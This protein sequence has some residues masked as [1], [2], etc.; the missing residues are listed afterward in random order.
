M[1]IGFSNT[2]ASNPMIYQ[3]YLLGILL[4]FILTR[5]FQKRLLDE[6]IVL[7]L[8]HYSDHSLIR[9]KRLAETVSNIATIHVISEPEYN[10]MDT[11]EKL[12]NPVG[13]KFIAT[14]NEWQDTVINKCRQ[15]VAIVIDVEKDDPS[16]N[17]LWEIEQTGKLFPEKTVL[18]APPNVSLDWKAKVAPATKLIRYEVERQSDNM[19]RDLLEFILKSKKNFGK[20]VMQ[21][22]VNRTP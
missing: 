17:V 2:A 20:N 16:P 8:R 13:V 3:A 21:Q 15:A 10:F 4:F 6:N 18:V 12:H 9:A 22:D 1:L 19:K 7:L 11:V 5:L 14:H